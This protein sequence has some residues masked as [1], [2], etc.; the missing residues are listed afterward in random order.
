[1]VHCAIVNAA[2]LIPASTL[3]VLQNKLVQP[4]LTVQ[5]KEQLLLN[6]NH[7]FQ[8]KFVIHVGM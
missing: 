6:F 4:K 2:F 7:Q 3:S 8:D 1:L 5:L